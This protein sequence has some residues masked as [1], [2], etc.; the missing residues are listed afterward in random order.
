MHK[1]GR[2]D[3]ARAIRIDRD[4]VAEAGPG[5]L[6]V[7]VNC[8]GICGSDLALWRTGGLYPGVV[9]GHE[10]CGT[11]VSAGAAVAGVNEGDRVVA[12]PMID[13]V[14]LGRHPGAFAEYLRLPDAVRGRNVF[15][16]PEAVPDEVGAMVEPFA[17]ALH[18]VRKGRAAPGDRVAVFGAGPIGL[19]VLAALRA[20]GVDRIVAIDP[21]ATRRAMAMAMGALATHD[22]LEGDSAAFVAGHFGEDR[23]AYMQRPL[24]RATIAFDCAGVNGVLDDCAHALAEG[25]RLVLVADP[26]DAPLSATRLVMMRELELIGSLAYHDEFDDGIALLASGKADLAPL[27]THRFA[28]DDLAEAFVM[29]GDAAQA[30]KVLVRP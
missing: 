19:C 4:E 17:V 6:L 5:D 22:P 24:S 14:G 27:V 20:I 15:V 12:N 16:L 28:L 3:G 2:L 1:V 26:H 30:V 9:L 7:R 23:L 25:G 18:A 29:Q 10:F 13:F 21:S 8:T 11:V